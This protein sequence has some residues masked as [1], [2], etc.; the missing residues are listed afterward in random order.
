M[1]ETVDNSKIRILVIDDDDLVRETIKL[2]LESAHYQVVEA[3]DGAVGLKI[4][5]QDEFDLVITDILMPNKEGIE[6]IQELRRARPT[7][8]IIAISGG[9]RRGGSFL[10]IAEKFGASKTLRKPFRPQELLRC[11][12][13][14]LAE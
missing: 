1:N 2:G 5:S 11:V 12:Q 8:K 4:A 13:D 6:T 3:N 10:E 9:D 14:L 7:L